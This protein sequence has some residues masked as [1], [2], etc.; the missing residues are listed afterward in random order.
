[1]SSPVEQIKQ[2]LTVVDV[3]GSYIKLQKAGGNFKAPCP[4]HSEKAPS[5][6]VSPAREIWHCFGCSRGGDIFEFVKEIEGVEFPEALKILADRAGITVTYENPKFRDEKTRLVDLLKEATVFYQKQLIANKKPLDYLR[7]RGLKNDTLKMF[8]VGFA[9]EEEKG[10]RNLFDYLKDKGY[11]AS[12]IE[13]A[14]LIIK[15][16]PDDYYDRFRSRIMFPLKDSPG[17]IVG[18]SGRI[19]GIKAEQ[20]D[21]GKYINT[22]QTVLYDKSKVLYGFD[23]AKFEIRKN[24][25]CILVEGQMDVLMAHQAGNTNTVAVSGTA[26]TPQHLEMIKRLTDNLIMAFDSDEA[27]FSAARRSIDL[28]LEKG[29]EVKAISIPEEKDPAEMILKSPDAWTKSVKNATHIIEFYLKHLN[30]KFDEPRKFKMEVSKQVLPYISSIQSEID[31]S[32][33]IGEIARRI[34]VGEE[35]VLAEVSK[36]RKDKLFKRQ[37]PSDLESNKPAKERRVLLE[38]RLAGVV[39]WKKNKKLI[40]DFAKSR[41][42]SILENADKDKN[43]QSKLLFEVELCYGDCE[44]YDMEMKHLLS[45]LKKET[46]KE[47]LG[48]L[49][50]EIQKMETDGRQDDINSKLVEFQ[51]ISKELMES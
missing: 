4:F 34:G 1:M 7:K 36:I 25:A 31:K 20:D 41:I 21:I 8:N 13:K 17:K 18:F 43:I 19:F 16:A 47:K 40:P 51:K 37:T 14:G 49:T 39:L 3:V 29:F 23:I 35:V 27:G 30:K 33:W 38:E 10:W 5:F 26:L 32:H 12:E 2:R 6:Y 48:K 42:L 45:E 24:D 50:Q 46:L 44:N 15:K 28:A 11:S 9:P 22:P